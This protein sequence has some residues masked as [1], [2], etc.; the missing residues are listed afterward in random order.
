MTNWAQLMPLLK[1]AVALRV[2]AHPNP[3]PARPCCTLSSPHST[4]L[5][6]LCRHR[7][8]VRVSSHAV[9][10]LLLL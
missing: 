7:E 4:P 2:A 9:S 8:R 3:P 5:S 6:Y 1:S 10:P